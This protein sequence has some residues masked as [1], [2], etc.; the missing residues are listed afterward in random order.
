MSTSAT[1]LGDATD[2]GYWDEGISDATL[3]LLDHIMGAYNSSGGVI[4]ES[5]MSS[6]AADE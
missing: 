6:N 3:N 1:I 2:D 4:E 5:G